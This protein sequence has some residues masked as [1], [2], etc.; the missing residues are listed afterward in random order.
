MRP[1]KAPWTYKLYQDSSWAISDATGFTFLWVTFQTHEVIGTNHR[2]LTQE[3]ARRVAANICRL[4]D[5]PQLTPEIRSAIER[6]TANTSPGLSEREAIGLILREYLT[7]T[8]DLPLPKAN[9][10]K[11]AG[12]K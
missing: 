8:G 7:G 1:L 11:A 4:P 2:R 3:E 5:Q 6:F 9:R 10:G 12:K